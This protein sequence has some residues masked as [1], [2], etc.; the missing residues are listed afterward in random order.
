[1]YLIDYVVVRSLIPSTDTNMTCYCL[2]VIDPILFLL[3]FTLDFEVDV[4][5]KITIGICP[6]ILR[7]MQKG[8]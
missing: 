3:I 1:M 4:N 7:S 6:E 8:M 2:S 5:K